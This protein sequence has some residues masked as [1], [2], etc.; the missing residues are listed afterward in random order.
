MKRL[1]VL[2]SLLLCLL[3]PHAAFAFDPFVDACG[4]GGSNAAAGSTAC[5]VNANQDP[6][7][8]PNGVIKRV[9]MLLGLI[10]G[11]TSVIIIIVS[12]FRYVTSNGDAQKAASARSGIVGAAVGLVII[13]ASTTI[14][15]FVVS[16][17]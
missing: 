1:I 12:G 7:S 13:A 16:K 14:V 17:L 8:G 3:V 4:A 2:G 10:A 11:M 5:S 15:V 6:I 9:T